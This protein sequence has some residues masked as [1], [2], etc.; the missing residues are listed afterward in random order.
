[1]ATSGFAGLGYQIVWT[2][3]GGLWLGHES[4][5]VLAVVAAF[6]GG[7]AVGALALGARIERSA[8]PVRWYAACEVVIGGWGLVLTAAMA[9]V[10]DRLLALTGVEP[11]PAWQW[12]V[13]FAGLF[14]LLLP[15]TAAMG[16]T[17]PAIERV[18][19]LW[20]A[21]GRSIAG[22][23]ASNTA[24]AV[25]GVLATTFWLIP[26]VG[27]SATATT[28]VAMNLLCAVF[29]PWLVKGVSA[30]SVKSPVIRPAR[31]RRLEVTLFM[32][33]LFGIGYE[34]LVVRVLAQVCE[35][36]VYTFAMLLAV[37]LAGTA[38]GAAAWQRWFVPHAGAADRERSTDRL[39]VALA[40]ACLT[41]L[42]TLWFAEDLQSAL[43]VAAGGG[44]S[45]AIAVEA[46]LAAAAFALPTIVM[47]A[48]FSQLATR[49][50]EAGIPFGRA[51]GVNIAGAAMAPLTFG[52]LLAPAI[53][54]KGALLCVV[55]GYLALLPIDRWRRPFAWV[56]AGIAVAVAVAAPRLAF[57]DVP[58]GGRIVSYRD[59]TMAAVSVV[60]DA[61]GVSR[62]RIDNRQQEGSTSSSFVDGRQALLPMLLHPAPRHALFLGLGTGVTAA[63]AASDR[64]LEV[65]AVELLP[66]VIAASRHFTDRLG[67]GATTPRLHTVA[68]DARRYIRTSPLRYDV[69]VADNFHPARG[70]S[71][72]LYTVEHFHRIRDRLADD[73]LFCQWLPLHQLD[74]DTL[75]SIVRS[76]VAVYPRG[77][78]LLASNSLG[79][80]VIGL[81][82]HRDGLRFDVRSV[83]ERLVHGRLVQPPSAFG[84]DDEYAL[85]GSFVAGPAALARF[86]GDADL[87]TDD[88]PVVAYRAPRATYAPASMP[89]DRLV[90]LLK[91]WSVEPREV[92]SAPEPAVA[93]R[94]AAYWIAR[95]RFI[96]VGRNVRPS[97]DVR[98]MLA[99]VGQ[100]LTEILETSPDFRPAYDPL[101]RMAAALAPVDPM[102]AGALLR[103]LVVLQ[104]ERPE[105][106][107]TLLR[108]FDPD[109]EQT[110]GSGR[111]PEQPVR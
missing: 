27:L 110:S 80:P 30:G 91:T 62:L 31:T 103:R 41:G 83:R 79:T 33:G 50:N 68:A 108:L 96:E 45:Q 24:G 23:Y 89:E 58:D 109:R 87:N 9:P 12:T 56:P 107:E 7:L 32:T 85:L 35:D 29:A 59:G 8:H 75:R 67:G 40:I 52:V 98:K 55:G 82:S 97:A 61:D 6:F 78:A 46:L 14:V 74:L 72:A 100:P 43:L 13:A 4:A 102:A 49:A 90:S 48:L 2:R 64:D 38:A 20:R 104:P 111:A 3:Q 19:S 70:G 76:F 105:A 88:R 81:V 10:G 92:L 47:G 99:R 26:S 34:V 18:V 63:T 95:N 25:L 71:G 60:E 73:G 77:G 28:C 69:I 16:A 101:L 11:T 51:I 86:A 1:M 44:L 57:V 21:D 93:E 36:T 54:P 65:D 84:L 94:L 53:G 42:G 37:Y 5:A 22:L 17:L 39:L 66:E 15:A 106:G